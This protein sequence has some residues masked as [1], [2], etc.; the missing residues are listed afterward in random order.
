MKSISYSKSALRALS[1]MPR[2]TAKLI[3][4]KIEL[5]AADP[6][7]L[8]NNV[9]ALRGRDEIRLRVGDWRVILVDG[10]VIEVIRIAARGDAYQ[11]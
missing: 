3:V 8:A 10:V 4:S 11:E 2:T 7:A 6:A 5:Y 9:K 1:R